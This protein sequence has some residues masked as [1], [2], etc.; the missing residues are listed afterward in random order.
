MGGLLSIEGHSFQSVL[1]IIPQGGK[2][3]LPIH[4]GLLLITNQ[5]RST[6]IAAAILRIDGTG[7]VL[8]DRDTQVVFFENTGALST[9]SVYK[10]S[11]GEHWMV[12][13]NRSTIAQI[14]Y[15]YIMNV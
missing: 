15:S 5:S 9:I 7:E 2:H 12:I 8:T 10:E 11:E 4:S 1:T 3:E 6:N 14:R 13:N